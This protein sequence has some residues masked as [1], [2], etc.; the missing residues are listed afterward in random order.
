MDW[1]ESQRIELGN[2]FVQTLINL[3]GWSVKQRQYTEAKNLYLRA[4][5]KDPFRDDIHLAFMQCLVYSGAPNAAI[6]HFLEYQKFLENEKLTPSQVV[7]D[8][9]R[10]LLR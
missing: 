1:T 4:I 6:N 7:V 5:E 8:Y 9:Y 2:I 10:H 3:A